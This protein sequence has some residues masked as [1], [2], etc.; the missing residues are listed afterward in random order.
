MARRGLATALQA[1]LAGFGGYGQG[2][3]AQ[4]ERQQKL[5]QAEEERKRREMLD[6]LD[7]QERGYMRPEQLVQARQEAAAPTSRVAQ[8][9][10]LSALS[11]TRPA[12]LP[13]TADIATVMETAALRQPLAGQQRITVGG[14]EYVRPEAPIVTERRE[15]SMAL[16]QKAFESA[17][18]RRFRASEREKDQAFEEKLA[19]LR[20]DADKKIAAMRA[21][22]T[23]APQ[24]P[25]EGQ[26]KSFQF[27]QRMTGANDIIAKYGPAARLD[28]ITAVLAAENPAVL[29]FFNR[30]LT[31][32]EQQLVTAI[33]QFSEPILRKNTGAA[34]NRQE[35]RWVEQQVIPLSGDSKEAQDYKA[36]V[37]QREIETMQAL[38]TPAT[39]YYE[40]ATGNPM[41][42]TQSAATSVEPRMAGESI[43]DYIARKNKGR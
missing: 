24:R 38:A 17:E 31:P 43:A 37:R 16:A 22:T 36:G 1:A 13:S 41:T 27:A 7:V 30:T 21:T 29:A 11:P 40:W 6:I 12:P 33:R 19:K 28:R 2:V 3:I 25:T 34:F 18:D 4:R 23:G 15:R 14:Q 26:E 10:I 20:I 8:S 5:S 32:E 42:S 9:A 35:I 39:R